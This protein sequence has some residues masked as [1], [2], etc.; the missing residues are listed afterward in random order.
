[1][2]KY[3]C[4][5]ARGVKCSLFQGP[6]DPAVSSRLQHINYTWCFS[7]ATLFFLPGFLFFFW[8]NVYSKNIQLH[9]TIFRDQQLW[10]KLNHLNLKGNIALLSAGIANC[11][12]K[13][14]IIT[15]VRELL[16]SWWRFPH[17]E[18]QEARF[19]ILHK[20]ENLRFL[21]RKV[22]LETCNNEKWVC[23]SLS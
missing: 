18:L 12:G 8:N 10:I 20:A 21:A 15:W 4:V 11:L 9:L 7:K 14:H 1:M 22:K 6:K 19:R 17:N 16:R 3:T 23:W 2:R 13:A 5:P